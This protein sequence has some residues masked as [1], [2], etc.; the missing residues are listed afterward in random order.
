MTDAHNPDTNKDWTPLMRSRVFACNECGTE[1]T[2]TT[3][4]TGTVWAHPCAGTCKLILRANTSREKVI[5]HPPT[6][7]SYVRDAE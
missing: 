7:H 4:H 2:F 5:W 6:P 1:D 3:N